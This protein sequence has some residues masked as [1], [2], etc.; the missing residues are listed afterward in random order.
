MSPYPESSDPRLHRSILD[1][2][3]TNSLLPDISIKNI[4]RSEQTTE[5]LRN[6]QSEQ[7]AQKLVKQI[8]ERIEAFDASLDNSEEVGI[9]LVSFGQTLTFHVSELGFIQPSLV[10]FRGFTE[11]EEPVELIQH[12]SQIS[13]LLMA[14]KR[15]EVK[16]EKRKIGFIQSAS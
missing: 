3:P 7:S 12:I 14:L 11:G 1:T 5:V 13:F 8:L 15:L 4:P 2:L 6:L 10:I 9:R 16:E